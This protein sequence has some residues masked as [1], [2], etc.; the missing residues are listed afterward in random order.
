MSKLTT[1]IEKYLDLLF[2]HCFN[3]ARGSE[4]SVKA[5]MACYAMF[6]VL[7]NICISLSSLASLIMPHKIL[8]AFSVVLIVLLVFTH[9]ELENRYENMKLCKEIITSHHSAPGPIKSLLIYFI[10]NLIAASPTLLL[11]K[12][13]YIT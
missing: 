13:K 5:S 12:L 11:I 1:T 3:W 9:C 4:E 6:L 2:F 7:L 10:Y 8:I